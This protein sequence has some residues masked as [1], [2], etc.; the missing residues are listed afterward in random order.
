[1]TKRVHDLV[2]KESTQNQQFRQKKIPQDFKQEI[3]P[4]APPNVAKAQGT[5]GEVRL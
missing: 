3:A 5:M 4:H 1:M 2:V